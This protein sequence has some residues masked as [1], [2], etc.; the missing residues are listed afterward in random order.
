MKPPW[1]H[2]DHVSMH[3]RP[4][5]VMKTGVIE[6]MWI[7]QVNPVDM[8][9]HTIDPF[10][11]SVRGPG[12]AVSPS[13]QPEQIAGAAGQV[14]KAFAKG[15]P[16]VIAVGL[17]RV[18]VAPGDGARIG[19]VIGLIVQAAERLARG[20]AVAIDLMGRRL[21]VTPDGAGNV[22]M[23]AE[24]ARQPQSIDVRN[25][26]SGLGMPAAQWAQALRPT[27]PGN[28]YSYPT[29][30]MSDSPYRETMMATV[31]TWAPGAA[32][33]TH[34]ADKPALAIQRTQPAAALAARP[35]LPAPYFQ[36]AQTYAEQIRRR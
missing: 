22:R 26:S 36:R 17:D 11:A 16:A 34:S 20:E 18:K 7:R 24:N 14:A 5:F 23:R 1:S 15:Q 12:P 19:G 3:W 25:G 9:R 32:A 13:P 2:G 30:A 21:I 29:V 8:A 27:G 6:P 35:A 28:V 10:I 33:Q 31:R 4:D